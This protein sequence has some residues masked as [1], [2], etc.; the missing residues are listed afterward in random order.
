MNM[1]DFVQRAGSRTAH[2]GLHN[3]ESRWNTGGR[4]LQLSSLRL[5]VSHQNAKMMERSLAELMLNLYELMSNL[6]PVNLVESSQGSPS[7]L[8]RQLT[9]GG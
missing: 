1:F 8:S 6:L 2:S 7:T 9:N 3:V 4:Q 5:K